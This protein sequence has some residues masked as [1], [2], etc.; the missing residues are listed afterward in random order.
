MESGERTGMSKIALL[1]LPLFLLGGCGG[2]SGT[3][4]D[5]TAPPGVSTVTSSTLSGRVVDEQGRGQAGVQMAFA[6]RLTDEGATAV[7]GADGSFSVTLPRGFYDVGMVNESDPLTA[8]SYYGPIPVSG[9]TPRDFVLK[10]TASH[11]SAQV[12]GQLWLR[13]GQPAGNRRVRLVPVSADFTGPDIGLEPAEVVTDANGQFT[14]ELFDAEGIGLN[15]EVYDADGRLD[16]AVDIDLHGRSSYVEF[17]TEDL[18]AE[19]LLGYGVAAQG[20]PEGL[21]GD[22]EIVS[23]KATARPFETSKVTR[24][25]DRDTHEI[26][27]FRAGYLPSGSGLLTLSTVCP[28][29][30]PP[31]PN[32]IGF[33][34]NQCN[35]G[36]EPR[37]E[38][39]NNVPDFR[40]LFYRNAVWIYLNTGSSN[41]FTDETEDHYTL[42]VASTSHWHNVAYNSDRPSIKH[43]Q[44]KFPSGKGRPEF[45]EGPVYTR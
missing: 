36:G 44:V 23:A 20:P 28:L 42:T 35:D 6:E 8:T 5:N 2:T 18:P 26:F 33:L 11:T 37:I 30:N 14:A 15:V 4:S 41:L 39:S 21:K 43:W 1:T 17:T 34:R 10:S 31:Y 16:E 24:E 32:L 25:P 22:V 29:N 7:T 19:N 27:D 3:V 9:A 12:F 40:K 13:P 45:P 38:V